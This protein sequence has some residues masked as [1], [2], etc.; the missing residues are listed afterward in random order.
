MKKISILMIGAAAL[1]MA[2]CQKS[3]TEVAADNVEANAGNMAENLDAA[4][5]NTTNDMASDT[6]SNQA[7]VIKDKGDNVA[8]N[9]AKGNMSEAQGNAAVNAM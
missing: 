6:L 4:A 9:V 1:S 5:S 3:A 7:E 8:D 2:A